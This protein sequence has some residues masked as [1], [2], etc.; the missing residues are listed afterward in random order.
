MIIVDSE[1]KRRI[2][3]LNLNCWKGKKKKTVD[4]EGSILGQFYSHKKKHEETCTSIKEILEG[5]TK[6]IYD[7]T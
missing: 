6:K 4:K 1:S 2:K 7:R 5:K 3:E